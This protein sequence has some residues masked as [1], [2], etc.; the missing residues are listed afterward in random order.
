MRLAVIALLGWLALGLIPAE[1][2]ET[3]DSIE[4][5]R[6]LIILK[7]D[8]EKALPIRTTFQA[9]PPTIAITFP[10]RRVGGSLPE[11]S[12]IA[13]GVIQTIS[14]RYE[15]RTGSG[16]SAAR[17]IEAVEIVLSAPFAYRVWSEPGRVVVAIEHPA[18]VMSG[19]FEVGLRGGTIIGGLR[20]G[21]VSERFRAMQEALALAAPAA[22]AMPV[23]PEP[24]KTA[25][26]RPAA[27]SPEAARQVVAPARSAGTATV[28]GAGR[29][30]ARAPS[31]HQW[32]IVGLLAIGIGGTFWWARGVER[33]RS[34]ARRA[35]ADR[36]GPRLPSGVILI[37]QLVWRAFERQGYQLVVETELMQPPLGTLRIIM[38][39]GVKA[40]LL[41]VGH[42]PFF[43]KQT[44]ERFL[45]AMREGDASQGFLV[46]AGSFTVPAQRVAKDHH[47]TLV[48]REQLIELLSVGAGSEYFTKQLEKAHAR[49]EEAKETLRQYASELDTLRRQRNEA[50]WYLREERA[51]VGKL[52]AQLDEATQQLRRDEADLARWSEEAGSLRRQ[53]EES[54][55]YLGEARDRGRHL[56]SQLAAFQDTGACAEA[57]Q[58]A[59]DEANWYL[60]EERA[61]GETVQAQL[62][63]LQTLVEAAAARE[64]ALQQD[65]AELRHELGAL[66]AHGERRGRSRVKIPHAFIELHEDSDGPVYVGAPRDV[67]LEG[68]GLETNEDIAI[69]SSVRVRLSVPGYEPIESQAQVMWRRAEG[70]PVRYRSGCRFLEL[71]ESARAGLEHFLETPNSSST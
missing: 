69:P 5:S 59:C 51:L 41:F 45:G 64:R 8:S 11:Q 57:L 17:F 38:K 6:T 65:L 39:D 47:I 70:D 66:R 27:A 1:A 16:V 58:R 18:S 42:G 40:A 22:G 33:I 15:S 48:G 4:M 19:A 36:L 49:L 32:N 46:A 9:R 62:A 31:A 10:S 21:R 2:V 12:T 61:K 35:P 71:S 34:W 56:E 53:W 67:S 23:S 25:A 54:Q 14:A 26:P 28:R 68:L 55:W 43:E 37:D 60:G 44:V 24:A 7:V 13:K 52:E 20:K 29:A 30:R 3:V 63:A 50:T